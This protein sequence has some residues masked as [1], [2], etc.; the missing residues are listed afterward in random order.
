MPERRL[1]AATANIVLQQLTGLNPTFFRAKSHASR[2]PCA[3]SLIGYPVGHRATHV[4]ERLRGHSNCRGKGP[5]VRFRTFATAGVA[6]GY[7]GV[8][9]HLNG[10]SIRRQLNAA[11][12]ARGVAATMDTDDE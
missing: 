9:S 6:E 2:C 11:L 12:E 8:F 4:S 10:M 7:E 5:V 1:Y 3:A